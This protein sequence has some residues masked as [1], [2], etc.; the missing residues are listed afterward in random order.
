M[1]G[2]MQNLTD[3][4]SE[5]VYV[6]SMCQNMQLQVLTRELAIHLA[7]ANMCHNMFGN[8]GMCVIACEGLQIWVIT[9]KGKSDYVCLHA[10]DGEICVAACI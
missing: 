6:E 3:H 7:Q 8:R 10:T 1:C 2:S 5:H 4:V 9:C